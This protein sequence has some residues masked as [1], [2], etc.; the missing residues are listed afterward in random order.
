MTNMKRRVFLKGALTA[1]GAVLAGTLVPRAVLAAW[2]AK[3]FDAK[4]LDAAEKDIF[5]GTPIAES[6][7]IHFPELPTLAQDARSVPINI[8]TTLPNVTQITLFVAKNPRPMAATYHL[9]DRVEPKLSMRVK[10]AKTTDVVAVVKS[11]GK[12]YSAKRKVKVTI[13]GCGG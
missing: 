2:P 13:G 9:S 11:D 10:M 4:S 12:L 7:K 8:A 6:G 3:A 1:G 5:G